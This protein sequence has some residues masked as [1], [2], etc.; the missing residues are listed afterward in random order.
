MK[1]KLSQINYKL[2]RG[3]V[4]VEMALLLVPLLMIALG[5]TEYGRAMFQYN[6]LTKTVRDSARYLTQFNPSASDYSTFVQNAKCLA[7]YGS[8]DCTSGNLVVSGL[9]TDMV[10]VKS[11][12][13][14]EPNINL[15]TVTINQFPFQFVINPLTFFGNKSTSI[16]FDPIQTTMRQ[17]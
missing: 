9:T 1:N 2:M 13:N 12:P 15:V 3:A 16:T 14:V 8:I 6:A 10:D 5:I 4:A 17:Q 7:V 11:I